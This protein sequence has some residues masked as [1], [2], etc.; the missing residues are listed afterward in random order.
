MGVQAVREK[1]TL[2]PV[3]GETGKTVLSLGILSRYFGLFV[4]VFCLFMG[5]CAHECEC[6]QMPMLLGPPGVTDS[7]EPS[8]MGAGN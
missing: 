2:L 1:L 4:F 5:V 7:C 3:G 6:Q 8:Y